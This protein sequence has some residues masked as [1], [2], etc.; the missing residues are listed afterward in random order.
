MA[1]REVSKQP[2]YVVVS[3]RAYVRRAASGRVKFDPMNCAASKPVCTALLSPSPVKGLT[4]PAASP[5]S[6]QSARC[7]SAGAKPAYSGSLVSGPAGRS[8]ANASSMSAS[9]HNAA[10]CRSA[11]EGVSSPAA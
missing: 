11:A 10:R 1:C 5:A 6:R 4:R 7:T 9:A 2:T 8:R 3:R